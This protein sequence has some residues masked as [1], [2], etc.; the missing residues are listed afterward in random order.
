MYPGFLFIDENFLGKDIMKAY[1][2]TYQGGEG[3]ITEKKS[4]FLA[5]V[6]PVESETEAI[7]LIAEIKKKHW[8]ATHNCYAFVIGERQEIQRYSD[9]GEPQGTAGRPILDVLL[10]EGIHNTAIVVTRHFGG[11]LLG[12]GG[13]VRAYTKAAK[14]GLKNS[15]VIEKQSGCLLK[16]ESDY[17]GFGKIQYL[18]GQRGLFIMNSEYSEVVTVEALIPEEL[19][20]SLQEDITEK[21][22]G[23]IK[24]LETQAVCFAMV[25]GT[26]VIF[27]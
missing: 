7:E 12:T 25:N 26:P 24:Y 21:T 16:M 23:R 22:N 8:N 18:L 4:R 27:I 13:L 15:I 9:D 14:E 3:E 1:K 5:A 19:L 20:A 17:S 2:T 10:G 6:L 11:T